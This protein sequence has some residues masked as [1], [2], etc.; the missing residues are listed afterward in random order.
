MLE[1]SGI[2]ENTLSDILAEMG[3]ILRLDDVDGY[4]MSGK[5]G[6]YCSVRQSTAKFIPEP[7][8]FSD[9]SE[10]GQGSGREPDN[11]GA[12]Q[13]LHHRND[14]QNESG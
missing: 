1:I 5:E 8:R 12:L 7:C 3:D 14:Q 4:Q 2:G 13:V 9:S 11:D 6:C 10:I